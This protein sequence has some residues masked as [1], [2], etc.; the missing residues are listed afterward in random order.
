[1]PR[2]G[3]S[4]SHTRSSSEF[5]EELRDCFPAAAPAPVPRSSVGGPLS[6]TPSSA[7]ISGLLDN[8]HGCPLMAVSG[9]SW[10][11]RFT[12]PRDCWRRASLPA[13]VAHVCVLFVGVYVQLRFSAH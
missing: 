6:S 2:N 5:S 13:R 12:S 1:M 7:S 3:I 10:R 9:A 11:F 4:G 8:R